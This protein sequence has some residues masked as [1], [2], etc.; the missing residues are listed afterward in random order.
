M[1]LPLLSAP[2]ILSALAGLAVG[3]N[4]A[5][6]THDAGGPLRTNAWPVS[7]ITATRD[8]QEDGGSLRRG[9]R[10][11]DGTPIAAYF[12][13]FGQEYHLAKKPTPLE[14]SDGTMVALSDDCVLA[15]LP[16]PDLLTAGAG[17]CNSCGLI[18]PAKQRPL[19]NVNRSHRSSHI[20][21]PP[22]RSLV[23]HV[24]V[25]RRSGPHRA[26]HVPRHGGG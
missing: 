26:Q 25:Q 3:A 21:T 12:Y 2:T 17:A 24:G 20:D 1:I 4:A 6:W 23:S 10:L 19:S 9:S 22:C 13:V 15:G 16:D 7:S 8:G 5:T 11:G 14:L 18:R